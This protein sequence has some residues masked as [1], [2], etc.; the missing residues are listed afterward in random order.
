MPSLLGIFIND[1][2][3]LVNELPKNHR[4]LIAGNFNL[5]QMLPGNVLKVDPLI[6]N[7]NLSILNIQL[8]Y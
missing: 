1:F 2:V 3:L 7:F 5:N 4:V 8:I 6:Q